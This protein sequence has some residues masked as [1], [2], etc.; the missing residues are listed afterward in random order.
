MGEGHTQS[1]FPAQALAGDVQGWSVDSV[2]GSRSFRDCH[3]RGIR[4]QLKDGVRQD[5]CHS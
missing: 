3:L 2:E 4:L 5:L 1:P